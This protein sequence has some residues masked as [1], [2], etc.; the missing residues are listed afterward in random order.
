ME[1]SKLTSCIILVFV[2]AA[3]EPKLSV[4]PAVDGGV[5]LQCEAS[6]WF[7]E[8][9]LTFLD[10]QG[11]NISAEDPKNNLDS[12]GCFTVTRRATVQ[13]ASNRFKFSLILTLMFCKRCLFG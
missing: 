5:T 12:S 11:N 3:S 8:P 13:T 1:S 4:V 7:P 2:V 6:C 9:E 10:E